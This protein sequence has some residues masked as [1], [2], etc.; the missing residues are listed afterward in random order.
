M[1]YLT[2][3]GSFRGLASEY[4]LCQ[5]PTLISPL[6][7]GNLFF[8]TDSKFLCSK[9][10]LTVRNLGEFANWGLIRQ[11]FICQL[12]CYTLTSLCINT[13]PAK[14]SLH[15]RPILRTNLP[16]FFTTKLFHYTVCKDIYHPVLS[17]FILSIS[18]SST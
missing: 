1:T 15:A 13:Q 18:H 17:D 3:Y 5:I 6:N 11:S 14:C 2:S 12:S 9:K 10:I 4:W 16:N 8:Q 7:Q